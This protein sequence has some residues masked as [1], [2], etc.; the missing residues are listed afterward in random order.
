MSFC[1]EAKDA[2]CTATPKRLCCK[3]SLI[4]GYLY[5]SRTFERDK[6]VIHFES[7]R[8]REYISKLFFDIFQMEL[9]CENDIVIDDSF[10]L[11]TLTDVLAITD[12]VQI[13]EIIYSCSQCSKSFMKGLFLSCASLNDPAKGYHMEFSGVDEERLEQ[14][15]GFF[16]LQGLT[17]SRST[18]RHRP[19]LYY[20]STQ[21]IERFL[22]YIGASKALFGV[23]N[24]RMVGEERNS[25]N[26]RTNFENAN[27]NRTV[28]AAS[29]QVSAAKKLER[30]GRLHLLSAELQE[31]A[32]LRIR[33]PD[34]SLAEL[35]ALHDPPITKSG[36]THRL[37]KLVTIAKEEK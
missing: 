19:I 10:T 30:M 25:I 28:S 33:H 4:Y 3:L 16:D 21:M 18:R 1:S 2:L 8:V 29:D 15:E 31:S 23:I 5:S 6:I 37:K 26:R 32:L 36:L 17:L 13:S 27:L 7:P 12:S 35:A 11:N 20:K 34:A 9:E 24:A 14:I 22:S